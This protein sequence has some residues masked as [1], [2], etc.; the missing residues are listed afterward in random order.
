MRLTAAKPFFLIF[1]LLIAFSTPALAS[2]FVIPTIQKESNIITVKTSDG[3]FDNPIDAMNSITDASET[4]PYLIVIGPGVFDIGSNQIIMKSHVGILGS[5]ENQTTITG[6]RSTNSADQFDDGSLIVGTDNA[7]LKSLTILNSTNV[8]DD[9]SSCI[10]FQNSTA[11]IEDVHIRLYSISDYTHGILSN[12]STVTLKNVEIIVDN[13][14][15]HS[16]GILA[17]NS[18]IIEDQDLTIIDSPDAGIAHAIS[19]VGNSE[20]HSRNLSVTVS[21]SG[22]QHKGV[23]IQASTAVIISANIDI[24]GGDRSNFGIT[25]YNISKCKLSESTVSTGSIPAPGG[26]LSSAAFVKDFGDT[27]IINNST[28]TAAQ[29]ATYNFINGTPHYID[30]IDSELEGGAWNS[31]C[32]RC[33]RNGMALNGSCEVP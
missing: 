1:L 19:I 32:I 24:S 4:N 13:G 15:A 20:L 2:F 5:G 33:S 22:T 25:L 28:L 11:S 16:Y 7:S 10:F 23:Y 8:S 31:D 14:T 9:N 17:D 6:S 3:D 29:F 12:N 21:G 18:S 27:A 26:W 30:I